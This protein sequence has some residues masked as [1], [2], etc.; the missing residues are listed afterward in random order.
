MTP[1]DE[2]K[3]EATF[4]V[5]EHKNPPCIEFIIRGNLDL[6]S[7]ERL[8]ALVTAWRKGDQYD[9]VIFDFKGTNYMGSAGWAVIF[10]ASSESRKRK[11]ACLV[12]GM[13]DDVH[14]SLSSLGAANVL[15]IIAANRKEALAIVEQEQKKRS[16][17]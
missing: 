12:H 2:N 8:K 4:D 5:L 15:C 13:S 17:D 6:F 11:G 16:K 1:R 7:Y 14:R 3:T 9:D 10:Q